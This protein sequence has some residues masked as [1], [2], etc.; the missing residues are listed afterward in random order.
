MRA[1]NALTFSRRLLFATTLAAAPSIGVVH[2]A[3][4]QHIGIYADPQGL[5]CTL[6][7]PPGSEATRVYVVLK[8]A[9]Y[10]G[11]QFAAPIPSCTPFA[12]AG[13]STPPGFFALGDPESGIQVAFGGCITGDVV[14]MRID[15]VLT[16]NPTGDCCAFRLAPYPGAIPPNGKVKVEVADCFGRIRLATTSAVW[17]AGNDVACAQMLPPSDPSPSDGATEVPLDAV[18]TCKVHP[19]EEFMCAMMLGSDWAN[20]YFGTSP[21]PP[22]VGNGGPIPYRP[23]SMAPATT[24][25]WK[26]YYNYWGVGRS[27]PIWSF[28]TASSTP[29]ESST[30]GRIKALY[31]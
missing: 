15:L 9:Q 13:W 1:G 3:L 26:V 5:D 12:I 2:E 6:D 28:T 20:V 27:S 10:E 29:V 18:L 11:V 8:Y 22:L 17:L 25:Y 23:R 24:Y 30:W 7:L 14:V 16:G 21:D 4:G 31:R 19:V